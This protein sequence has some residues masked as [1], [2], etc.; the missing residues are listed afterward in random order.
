MKFHNIHL[1]IFLISISFFTC[2][3]CNKDPKRSYLPYSLHF[4]LVQPLNEKSI[5]I[6]IKNMYATIEAK[7]NKNIYLFGYKDFKVIFS[8]L[9]P[10]TTISIQGESV[11]LTE[12]AGTIGPAKVDIDI[13]ASLNKIILPEI[14]QIPNNIKD[15]IFEKDLNQFILDKGIN[16][17][18]ILVLSPINNYGLKKYIKFANTDSLRTYI[19]NKIGEIQEFYIIYKP[20]IDT[21]NTLINNDVLA[22]STPK[23]HNRE[24]IQTNEPGPGMI[25]T[26]ISLIILENNKYKIKL[27]KIK[28][29]INS[30][31]D[32]IEYVRLLK[33]I[34]LYNKQDI[35]LS[36]KL[37]KDLNKFVS[38]FN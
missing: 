35:P 11:K 27:E 20:K 26:N 1:F 23:P 33:W 17:N 28:P 22:Q 16:N 24:P 30:Q 13:N 19:K 18:Q 4:I 32:S 29:Y 9:K 8:R 10:D 36:D 12:G 15:T 38:E 2:N 21:I 37:M 34:I 5:P 25:N 31:T 14:F 3:G 6:D 7:E